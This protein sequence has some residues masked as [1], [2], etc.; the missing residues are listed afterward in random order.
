MPLKV[1]AAES[2]PVLNPVRKGKEENRIG[3]RGA[4]SLSRF[5]VARAARRQ[6]NKNKFALQANGQG[7]FPRYRVLYA[8]CPAR[9]LGRTK[10]AGR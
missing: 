7:S 3:K 4:I 5:S 2:G 8:R 10:A 6:H 1:S 9:V